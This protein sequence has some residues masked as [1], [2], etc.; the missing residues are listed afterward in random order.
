[1]K[2]QYGNFI[3][4][5][6]NNNL[7]NV[8]T[9]MQ[10]NP[11]YQAQLMMQMNNLMNTNFN[12][13]NQMIQFYNMI[14]SNPMFKM[15]FFQMFQNFQN[16][17]NMQKYGQSNPNKVNIAFLNNAR[18][19]RVVIQ[20]MH[21][22]YMSEVIN[23]YINKSGDIDMNNMY[24]YNGKR[25]IQNLTVAELGIYD[26]CEIQVVNQANVQGGLIKNS[27]EHQL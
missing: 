4:I 27:A 11:M 5:N 16:I 23:R 17:Q 20:A 12:Q 19:G 24:L 25:V 13:Q 1:M 10:M 8:G 2:N 22:E 9:Q 26:G 15:L 6:F 14:N 3:N 7:P 21:N 18:D